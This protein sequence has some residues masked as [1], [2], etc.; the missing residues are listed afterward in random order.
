MMVRKGWSTWKAVLLETVREVERKNLTLIAA[1]VAFFGTLALF[2]A[3]G[4]LI[5]IWG[6][7]GDPADVMSQLDS[8]RAVLPV[9]VYTLLTDQVTR[10]MTADESTLSLTGILS[11]GLAIWLARAG[12]AAVMRSMN[13]VYDEKGRRGLRHHVVAF[14]LTLALIFVAIVALTSVVAAPI[15]LSILPLGGFATF[16]VEAL[17]WVAAT[18][19][20]LLGAGLIYRIGPNRRAAQVPWISPGAIIAVTLWTIG[21][22]G[23]SAYLQNFGNYNEVYGSIGA[24]VALLIW[25]FISAF[26]LLIGAVVNAQLERHTYADSTVGPPKPLGERGA[27]AADTYVEA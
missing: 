16:A 3:I 24:V 26:L 9:D 20:L 23:F 4:A 18:G 13:A 27:T 2:P 7:I 1:G 8:V 25:L 21:S 19:V 11:L 14:G 10:P 5:A 6:L 22:V 15:I 12:V 17:R